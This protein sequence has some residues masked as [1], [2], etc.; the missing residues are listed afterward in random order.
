[1]KKIVF[2]SF[3][4]VN[5]GYWGQQTT[6]YSHY[7]FN[8]FAYNPAV[9]GSQ[10]CFNFKLGFRTQWV[11]FEGNPQTGF[12]SFHTRLKFKKSRTNRTQH[13]VGLYI[14]NDVV[15]YL[16]TTTLNL[17]YAYHFQMSRDVKASVGLYAGFQQFK[18][19][20]AKIIAVDYSDPIL[21]TNA[22]GILVP[23]ITPGIFLNHDDW[24][25]GLAI[26]QIV[27]NKWSKLIGVNARNK[28]HYSLVGGKR[29]KFD[30]KFN[31]VASAMLKYAGF[32]APSLDLNLMVELNSLVEMGLLYRNQD[33]I[34]ALIKFDFAKFFSLAYA[35]DFTTSRIRHASSN[36]HELIIG[37]SACPHDS[38]N[39][40][41]CPV[42]D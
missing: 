37:I 5:L 32:S 24:F 35:F 30:D 7:M 9:A 31:I 34:S 40:Y 36:T 11:G 1:M 10:D 42:F 18:V 28:F 41:I 33:A 2:I 13:G 39:T 4:L 21:N 15:G 22:S 6:Q 17:A 20:A 29:F 38:K 8:Y 19:D 27:R 14:E 26:R 25:A 16:G 23:Y 12:A 3:L